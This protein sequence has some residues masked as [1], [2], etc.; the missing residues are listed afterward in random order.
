MA[1]VKGL[2]DLAA[3]RAGVDGRGF[4]KGVAHQLVDDHEI[5]AV[6]VAVGGEGVAQGMAARACPCH[7]SRPQRR[8]E[9]R[10]GPLHHASR[11]SPAHPAWLRHGLCGNEPQ[12]VFRGKLHVRFDACPAPDAGP[13]RPPDESVCG[14]FAASFERP[15]CAVGKSSPRPRA[16]RRRASCAASSAW[17]GHPRGGLSKERLSTDGRGTVGRFLPAWFAVLDRLSSNP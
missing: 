16:G 6:L 13:P 2:V 9:L 7:R 4:P 8:V 14:C 5:Q 10:T 3:G 15:A 17:T 12:R 1:P 11:H